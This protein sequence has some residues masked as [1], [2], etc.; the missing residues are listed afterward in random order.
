MACARARPIRR[1]IACR[2]VRYPELGARNPTWRD[3]RLRFVECS[4]ADAG[5]LNADELPPMERRGAQAS[6][7]RA[8]AGPV[9]G[10]DASTATA[11]AGGGPRRSIHHLSRR[12]ALMLVGKRSHQAPLALSCLGGAATKAVAPIP[13]VPSIA[14]GSPPR[15]AAPVSAPGGTRTCDTQIKRAVREWSGVA[16]SRSFGAFRAIRL[17]RM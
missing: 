8:S 16:W 10:P 15:V 4:Q 13:S 3:R 2:G 1:P 9:A 6:R 11:P 17:P 5:E 14:S 7:P 12:P